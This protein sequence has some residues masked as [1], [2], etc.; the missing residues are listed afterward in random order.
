MNDNKTPVANISATM[1]RVL[2]LIIAIL[3]GVL[4]SYATADAAVRI[5]KSPYNK[6]V[7]KKKNHSYS[8]KVLMQKH[9]SSSNTIVKNN[10]RRPK[11][12]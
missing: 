3:L 5:E 1:K 4:L 8:C 7:Q 10:A 6:G 11:W 2:L 9:R 12:R